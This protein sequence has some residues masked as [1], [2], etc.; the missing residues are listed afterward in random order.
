MQFSVIQS[1]AEQ[2]MLVYILHLVQMRFLRCYFRGQSLHCCIAVHLL[3]IGLI[4]AC[5][6]ISS[7][8]VHGLFMLS[9][10]ACLVGL[11]DNGPYKA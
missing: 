2:L 7:C 3:N 10:Y 11:P 1:Q 5:K 6:L 9:V 8:S 4:S